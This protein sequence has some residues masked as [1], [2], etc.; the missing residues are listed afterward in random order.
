MLTAN[1]GLMLTVIAWGSTAPVI[2]E[3]LKEWDPIVLVAARLVVTSAVFMIWLRVVEGRFLGKGMVPVREVLILGG[4]LALFTILLTLAIR[5]SNP[6]SIAVIGAAGPIAASL[7]NR[8]LTGQNPPG[9]VMNAIPIVVVGGVIADVDMEA[10]LGGGDA[11]Y[12][13]GGEIIM[14]FC[15]FLWP[16]Y[17]SLM[18]R[19][20]DGSSQLRRT[21]LSFA[22]ATPIVI[23]AAVFTI[24][25]GWESLPARI[26]DAKGWG[27]FLWATFATSIIGTFMWNVSVGRLGVV[28]ATMVLNL[29]PGVAIL[30]AMIFGIEPRIEQIIGC[31]LV[32]AAVGQAQYRLYFRKGDK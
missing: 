28:V 20:F 12:F 30:T 10:L 6:I 17:S 13:Q 21:T 14:V 24:V 23:C 29:I 27:L 19:W 2:H 32:I 15:V 22:S 9:A 16:L 8:I 18:Q 1:L 7:I 31:L 25:M 11:L 4:I 5:F 3:L 26:P